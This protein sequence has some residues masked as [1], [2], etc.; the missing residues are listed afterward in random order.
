MNKSNLTG[1]SK[2]L[3]ERAVAVFLRGKPAAPKNR[4]AKRQNLHFN[5]TIFRG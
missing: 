2:R 3:H 4:K 1:F 5:R